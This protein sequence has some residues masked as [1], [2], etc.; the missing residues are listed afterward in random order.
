MGKEIILSKS[1]YLAG[2][3]C[4]KYLWTYVNRPEELP[5]PD[6]ATQFIF[7]NGHKVGQKA[8]ELYPEG[9]EID[10]DMGYEKGIS[11]TKDWLKQRRT[12]F[13]PSIRYM[14]TFA[15]ADILEPVGRNE[16]DIIEVKSSTSVKD[17]NI[18]DLSF[19]KYC[20]QGAGL[21]I[22]KCY[23]LYINRDYVK[24]GNID[25]RAFF[26]KSDVST[27]VEERYAGIEK[28][29]DEMIACVKRAHANEVE[30]GAHCLKPYPCILKEQ[31]FSD[32]RQGN[33]F[34]LYQNKRLANALYLSDIRYVSEITIDD[35]LN[36]KQKIQVAA[37]KNDRPYV[38]KKALQQF[39]SKIK[40]PAYFFDFET[41]ATAIP[42]F[43]GSRPYQN[44]PF[45]FSC[46]MLEDRY[47][48]P[49]HYYFLSEGRSDPREEL[50]CNLK[51][52][53]KDKNIGSVIVYYENFEKAVLKELADYSF[54]DA[55]WIMK[56]IDKIVDLYAP[57]GSFFYYHPEQKGSA[58]LKSVLPA[59]TG[60]HY[61]GMQI[62]NGQMASVSYL[63]STFLREAEMDAANIEAIRKNLLD[64]CALDT[65]GMIYILEKLYT[66]SKE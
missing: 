6:A 63:K 10:Y 29:I 53:F 39:L 60:I 46:H 32:L 11:K 21:Q 48:R 58:S 41:F 55:G 1:K 4:P 66:V 8:K 62:D 38:N 34:E 22:R 7:E 61:D 35:S 23:L 18:D 19:Q 2:L 37:V 43:E 13:E 5:E 30:I 3:Q 49:S 57:F 45:Q 52:I 47:S 44:I 56:I 42:L 31:C 51:N 26:I 20:Y 24:K 12:L 15:R 50:I 25:P 9:I 59:L 36:E 65:E 40:Y 14:H 64:Y 17:I 28:R 27:L 16:W 33:V 54:K